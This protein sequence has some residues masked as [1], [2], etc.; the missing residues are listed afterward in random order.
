MEYDLI[1]QMS[2]PYFRQL[3]VN[4]VVFFVVLFYRSTFTAIYTFDSL[5]KILAMGF[6]IGKFT[7]L[8]DPFN[9]L[10]FTVIVMA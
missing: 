5:I 3:I 1:P 10:D 4:P 6:C 9:W 7:F 2:S 8:R